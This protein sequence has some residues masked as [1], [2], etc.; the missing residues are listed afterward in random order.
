[1]HVYA[2]LIDYLRGV[3]IPNCTVEKSCSIVTNKV[4]GLMIL[5]VTVQNTN[6]VFTYF[7]YAYLIYHFLESRRLWSLDLNK[8]SVKWFQSFKMS[9]F[10]VA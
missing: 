9:E 2:Y 8:V 7:F 3:C 6:F 10:S 1:M 4:V 5:G